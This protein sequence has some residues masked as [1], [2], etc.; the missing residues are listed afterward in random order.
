MS[1]LLHLLAEGVASKPEL[2]LGVQ[3]GGSPWI[4]VIV[5]LAALA[6]AARWVLRR[7]IAAGSGK[8]GTDLV[9]RE[10]A[11]LGTGQVAVVEACGVRCLVGVT[12]S[13]ITHLATLPPAQ[14]SFLDVLDSVAEAP[15]GSP[16]ERFEKLRL[17]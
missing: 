3:D 6:L 12:A 11:T 14:A 5:V 13:Q 10:S 7:G 1:P 9:V 15:A 4:P 8:R 16:A 17:T 2:S